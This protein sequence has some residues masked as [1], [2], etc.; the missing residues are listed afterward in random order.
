MASLSICFAGRYRPLVWEHS[1]I[2]ALS[3]I[4]RAS[5]AGAADAEKLSA[6]IANSARVMA[7]HS[8]ASTCTE[9]CGLSVRISRGPHDPFLDRITRAFP[10]YPGADY[11]A[12]VNAGPETVAA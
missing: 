5:I 12:V 3:E 7:R 1:S 9:H 2:D 11:S 8:Y 4:A 10:A 6:W